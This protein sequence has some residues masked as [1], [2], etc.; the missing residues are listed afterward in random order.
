[1]NKIS[2]KYSQFQNR[3]VDVGDAMKIAK[4]KMEVKVKRLA[5]FDFD[6]TVVDD[7]TDIVVRDLVTKDKISSEVS[8]LYKKSGWTD[9][10]QAIFEILHSNGITRADIKSAVEAIPEVAGI[11]KLICELCD[12]HNFEVIVISD[13]NSEFIRFWC[14]FHDMS[15]FIKTVFTNPAEFDEDGLLRIR[16]FHHQTECSLSSNNLCKGQILENFMQQT[17]ADEGIVYDTVYYAGDGRNDLC[18]VLRID[19]C[20]FGCVRRGY[21]LEKE[22]DNILGN[23]NQDS[24]VKLDAQ[25]LKW[26]DGNELL[27]KL[28]KTFNDGV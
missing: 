20:D 17:Q 15:K 13:S 1:M 8:L 16:P 11:K 23:A 28:T 26:S 4:Q 27:E 6:H 10:M 18:P 3:S 14:E 2:I 9:Y 7:N 21:V 19:S 24:C 12:K 25:I 5:V 22:I